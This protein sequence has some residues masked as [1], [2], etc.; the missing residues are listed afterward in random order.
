MARLTRRAALGALALPALLPGTAR[1]WPDRPITWVVPFAAGGVT[2]GT[3]RLMAQY[4]APLLGKPVVVENRPGAGGSIGAEFVARTAPDGHT[5]LYGSQGPMVAVP[6]MQQVRYDAVRDFAPVHGIS[7]SPHVLLVP[8][9][10]PWRTLRD[11]VEAAR[12]RPDSLTYASTGVGTSPHLG[13]ELLLSLTGVKMVHAPY[14][15]G[16]QAITDLVG[17]RLDLM[18]D[19][20]LSSGAHVR[21]GRLRALAVTSATRV[22]ILPDV[23]TVGEA[24]YPAAEEIPWAGVFLPAG[25]P[26]P[27]VARLAE[28]IGEVLR[29]PKVAEYLD[30]TGSLALRDMG[31]E[32]LRSFM[33]EDTTR[34]REL[35]RRTGASSG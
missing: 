22:P 16:A 27:V 25:T 8:K 11:L 3:S 33:A 7:A 14:A 9:D 24:G 32:Q 35:I 13:T 29:N 5:V 30:S 17:G 12:A 34:I 1:A 2:D 10:R 19:Y 6:A 15:N 20:P 23:P 4:L 31:P 28:A 21:D 26:A 18:Y